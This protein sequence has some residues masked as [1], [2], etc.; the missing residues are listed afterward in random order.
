MKHTQED[1]QFQVN[2]FKEKKSPKL[3]L[4]S[5]HATIVVIVS[6][7]ISVKIKFLFSLSTA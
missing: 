4:Q 1:F 5:V 6:Q 2:K 7:R 3:E